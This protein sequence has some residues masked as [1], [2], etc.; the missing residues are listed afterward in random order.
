MAVWQGVAIDSLKFHLGSMP[1][2]SK[3]CGRATPKTA[4][5][6]VLRP[7]GG[8]PTAIFYLFGHPTPI[9]QCN[10]ELKIDDSFCDLDD[11]RSI[12][13]NHHD[14]R[15]GRHAMQDRN[16]GVWQG[17]V[18]DSL[19]FHLGQ[20]CLSLLHPAGGPPLRPSSTPSD[21][22][23]RTPLDMKWK[24]PFQR[25]FLFVRYDREIVTGYSFNCLSAIHVCS[26]LLL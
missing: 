3:P 26:L 12:G 6:G 20:P 21:T 14:G 5:S 22:P 18:M 25:W 7:Q 15:Y 13:H 16:V 19:K 4:V 24:V 23:C 10:I 1:Y 2:L 8:W 17:V 9:C 11:G